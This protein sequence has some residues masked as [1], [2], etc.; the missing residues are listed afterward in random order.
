MTSY[1][2]NVFVFPGLGICWMRCHCCD[3][4]QCRT[5]RLQVAG[6][7][8]NGHG[9][10][11]S[12][13][14]LLREASRG[15]G[16]SPAVTSGNSSNPGRKRHRN[17]VISRI[18]S[19]IATSSIVEYVKYTNHPIQIAHINESKSLPSNNSSPACR[20]VSSPFPS[21]PAHRGPDLPRDI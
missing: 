14:A 18:R 15:R 9:A 2:N 7:S 20:H 4:Y 17:I 16:H 1:L 6:T 12:S 21:S 13:E 11:Y 3:V 5:F 19:L 8:L 10:S